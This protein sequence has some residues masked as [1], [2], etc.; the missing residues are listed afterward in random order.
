MVKKQQSLIWQR[1][2]GCL[3]LLG[4]TVTFFFPILKLNYEVAL[5]FGVAVVENINLI[6]RQAQ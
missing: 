3:V 2:R 1:K 5:L 4:G 6:I